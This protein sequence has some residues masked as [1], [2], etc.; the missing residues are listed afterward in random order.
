MQIQVNYVPSVALG[1]YRYAKLRMNG[2]V[3]T[4]GVQFEE[5]L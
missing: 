4:Y 5:V 1:V 2:T 3:L